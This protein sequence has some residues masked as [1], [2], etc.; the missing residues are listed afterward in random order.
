[1][2]NFPQILYIPTG[3]FHGS[4]SN[5]EFLEISGYCFRR[6]QSNIPLPDGKGAVSP[7]YVT[8]F[9]DCNDCLTPSC[10][11]NMAFTFIGGFQPYNGGAASIVEKTFNFD[12]ASTGWVELMIPSGYLNNGTDLSPSGNGDFICTDIRCTYRD[13]S[14]KSG[15]EV[16]FDSP[17]TKIT[18]F[19]YDSSDDLYTRTNL[20]G[21][22]VSGY[23]TGSSGIYGVEPDFEYLNIF[24]SGNRQTNIAK[25]IKFYHDSTLSC[26]K[27]DVWF[28]MRGKVSESDYQKYGDSTSWEEN[29]WVYLQCKDI[30]FTPGQV[31]DCIPNN[32]GIKLGKGL[33][34]ND[35]FESGD[36]KAGN[37]PTIKFN[38]RSIDVVNM[39]LLTGTTGS[40]TASAYSVT[41][42]LHFGHFSS[43]ENSW[44]YQYSTVEKGGYYNPYQGYDFYE[45]ATFD[46]GGYGGYYTGT[47]KFYSG[48]GRFNYK[49]HFPAN[50]TGF[51]NSHEFFTL[52]RGESTDTQSED[53]YQYLFGETYG[54]MA[55]TPSEFGDGLMKN[56]TYRPMMFT[57]TITGHEAH[58]ESFFGDK[59]NMEKRPNWSTGV[60]VFQYYE[61]G[62]AHRPNRIK[63]WFGLITT[64][65]GKFDHYRHI[66]ENH[67]PVNMGNKLEIYS[68]RSGN[69]P[70]PSAS[71]NQASIVLNMGDPSLGNSPSDQGY[72][73]PLRFT[74]QDGLTFDYH[75]RQYIDPGGENPFDDY[76]V[77]YYD[78]GIIVSGD[79]PY[80]VNKTL[81]PYRTGDGAKVYPL[82][83]DSGNAGHTPS[84]TDPAN[85]FSTEFE[86]I[87]RV[88]FVLSFNNGFGK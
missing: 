42:G 55:L 26:N 22:L 84:T 60:Y 25:S 12:V 11:A 30:P 49:Y 1:M 24:D 80:Y 78:G 53:Y 69:F 8:G 16:S 72:Q 19:D 43:D 66:V 79:Y 85:T 51:A 58:W 36:F 86:R 73:I 63:G 68:P 54:V 39:P 74:D 6:V 40:A 9:S 59:F 46:D 33:S 17:D 76:E 23:L 44:S 52:N 67:S 48:I 31:I 37:F 75:R 81:V 70:V 57:G 4:Q 82:L 45:M 71:L 18:K 38:P 7:S 47:R 61:S 35:Y 3:Q 14:F 29:S 88:K 50:E 62:D 27:T 5:Y 2:A 77:G 65:S 32:T 87:D 41:G 21:K 15:I 83:I 20:Q 13:I 64:G 28:R 10:P 56:G 34:F